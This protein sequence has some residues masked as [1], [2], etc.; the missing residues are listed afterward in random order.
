MYVWLSYVYMCPELL[1]CWDLFLKGE[2]CLGLTVCPD[3]N[4]DGS[5]STW[6]GVRRKELI[7]KK[8]GAGRR[9]Q[10]REWKRN[11]QASGDQE[12]EMDTTTHQCFLSQNARPVRSTRAQSL[13]KWSNP[14][15]SDDLWM[16]VHTRVSSQTNPLFY[17]ISVP[18]ICY[19]SIC[20]K[21]FFP[22]SSPIS[23]QRWPPS[24]PSLYLR[25]SHYQLS[26]FLFLFLLRLES[27][28]SPNF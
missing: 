22:I 4:R 25:G 12:G 18:F 13:T 15:S 17:C 6:D 28:E 16:D 19:S 7:D 20:L 11:G 5:H 26:Y 10:K 24:N 9:K 1:S 27:L 23:H 3:E 21:I 14:Q 2:E 8:E